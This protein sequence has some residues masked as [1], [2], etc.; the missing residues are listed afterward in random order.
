[1][2]GHRLAS[3][4]TPSGRASM[5]GET[6]SPIALAAFK[7]ITSLI[8]RLLYR[9]TGPLGCSTEDRLDWRRH[10]LVHIAC[11][12]GPQIG[13][14]GTVG[15]DGSNGGKFPQLRNHRRAMLQ[16]AVRASTE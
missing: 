15:R 4:I 8:R 13:T 6:S 2:S 7:L 12:A 10:D 11:E 1:M 16:P 3:S 14:A 5:I 9:K